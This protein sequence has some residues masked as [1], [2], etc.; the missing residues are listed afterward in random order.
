MAAPDAMRAGVCRASENLS[1]FYLIS[2]AFFTRVKKMSREEAVHRIHDDRRRG[3]FFFAISSLFSV[4]FIVR[5]E[6]QFVRRV[7]VVWEMYCDSTRQ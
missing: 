1:R 5:E 2:P 3:N 7:C 4:K 6:R